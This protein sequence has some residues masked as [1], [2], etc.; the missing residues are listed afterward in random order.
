MIAGKPVLQDLWTWLE[1]NWVTTATSRHGDIWSVNKPYS[2]E[3]Q[4]RVDAAVDAIYRSFKERV[5]SARH[6]APDQV[7]EVARG[8][9]WTGEQAVKVGLV[10]QVGGL[11]DALDVVRQRIGL[12]PEDPV[13]L[14]ALPDREAAWLH[15]VGRMARDLRGAAVLID[16]L[17]GSVAAGTSP[18]AMPA[19]TIR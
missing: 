12:R 15:L 9:V 11:S 7:E 18:V 5:A 8:R 3:E 13:E 17:I 19:A 6:M 2:P 14:V 1:V 4:A 10:D 16:R